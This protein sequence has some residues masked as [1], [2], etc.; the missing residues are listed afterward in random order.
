[1]RSPRRD[2]NSAKPRRKPP[3]SLVLVAATESKVHLKWLKIFSD[4]E[5]AT[6]ELFRTQAAWLSTCLDWQDP[7]SAAAMRAHSF[8]IAVF[9]FQIAQELEMGGSTAR[10]LV[11]GEPSLR[12]ICHLLECGNSFDIELRVAVLTFADQQAP[13]SPCEVASKHY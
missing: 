8:K 12:T 2:A 11:G 3:Q 13:V 5:V 7:P 4:S 9:R 10:T 1:M 6:L